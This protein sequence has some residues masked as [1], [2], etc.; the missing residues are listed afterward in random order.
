MKR[1]YLVVFLLAALLL[2]GMTTVQASASAAKIGLA[3]IDAYVAQKAKE[4]SIPGIAYA[5][6]E[7]GKVVRLYAFGVARPDGMPMTPQTPS[8]IGSVGK[9]M[10]ALAAQQL[11]RAG[12]LDPDA[13][14]QQY[15]PGFRLAD[16]QVSARITVRNLIEHTSGIPTLAGN[17]P[18]FFEVGVSSDELV[19]RM[20]TVKLDRPVGEG[21]EYSNLNYLVLGKVI[22][23]A[24]GMPYGEYI[25]AAIFKPLEMTHSFVSRQAALAAGG[26]AGYHFYYGIPVVDA[27]PVPEGEIAA[28]MHFSSAEDMAHYLIAFAGHGQYN[29][30]SVVNP[31]GL[32]H[33]EDA[34]A[35][36]NIDWLPKDYS[37]G[38][39]TEGHSGAWL[40]YSAGLLFMPQ[41]QVG[42]VVLANAT[43]AQLLPARSAFEIAYDVLRLYTGNPVGPAR[44]PLVTLYLILDAVLLIFA[45]LVA[46]RWLALRGRIRVRSMVVDL[47]LPLVLLFVLP[48]VFAGLP[49]QYVLWPWWNWNRLFFSVPDLAYAWFG[50]ALAWLAAGLGKLLRLRQQS[51]L[52]A[53]GD[54]LGAGLHG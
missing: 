7:D 53:P 15:L 24:A 28:G 50:L 49:G 16:A 37:K 4:S 8:L 11:I 23:A 47:A 18:V 46:W 25:Q 26:A 21:Y 10:T 29:G 31:D 27:S 3:D 14:V 48:I 17:A 52:S 40:T 5:I 2:F 45:G 30:I 36:F 32:A 41:E 1:A 33:P 44:L 34:Q 35:D 13:P 39:N 6:V 38:G 20:D 22:E 54:R 9:T 12:K 19:R 42:V 51:H 43:P